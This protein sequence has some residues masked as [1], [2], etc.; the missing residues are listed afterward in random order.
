M[1]T[2]A[3]GDSHIYYETAGQGPA[4]VFIHSFLCDG[5]LFAHQIQA[6]A[7]AYRVINVDL[8]GHGR[9]GPARF[10]FSIYDLSEDV[11]KVLVAEKVTSAVWIGLSIGGFVAMRAALSKAHLVRALVLMDTEAGPQS[12][13]RKFQDY[14]LKLALKTVGFSAV[15]SS[16]AS[17]L[18]GKTTQKNQPALVESFK[19]NL[20]KLDTN[21]ICRGI[22]AVMSRDDVRSQLGQIQCPTLVIVG[23][24]DVPL[25]VAKSREIADQIRGSQSVV[26]PGAGHLSAMEQPEAVTAAITQFLAHLPSIKA[27]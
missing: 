18:F 26:I 9:S 22:D 21:S 17:A 10:P 15:T 12:F 7:R 2:I 6:L 20:L 23:E 1:P 8:R 25:P 14:G 16:I 13:S 5:T 3:S 19:A 27:I 4:V 11:E 24:E